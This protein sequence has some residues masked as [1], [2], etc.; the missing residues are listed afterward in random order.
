[1][2]E[3]TQSNN[4][5]KRDLGQREEKVGARRLDKKKETY[6]QSRERNTP[7]HKE[8]DDN[9]EKRCLKNI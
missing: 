3:N 4:Q 9:H 5:K 7:K 6:I 1:M 2:K 8:T